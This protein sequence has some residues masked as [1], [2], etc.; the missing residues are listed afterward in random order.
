MSIADLSGIQNLYNDY[1]DKID[2]YIITNERP[3]EPEKKQRD[4]KFNFTI[5]YLIQEE[6]M[7][8]DPNKIPSGYIIDKQGI[9][10]AEGFGNTRWNSDK[11]RELL[12][13]LIKN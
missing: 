7:P 3:E 1:K 11:V 6:K 12:D 10:V 2:F 5:T 8:F 4:R 13:N 9:V